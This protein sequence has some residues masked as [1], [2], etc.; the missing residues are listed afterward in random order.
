MGP[1]LV[2]ALFPTG[3]EWGAPFRSLATAIAGDDLE[4]EKLR[5]TL[6][7]G[8][9]QPELPTDVDYVRVMS[10][11]KSKGLTADLVVVM[12]C[13]E[14]LLPTLEDDLSQHEEARKL[15]EQRRLFYIAITRTRQ[16]LLL[17]SV[18]QLPRDIA[19]RMGARVKGGNRHRANTIASR[20]LNELGPSRPTAVSG[21]SILTNALP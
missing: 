8:I 5:E 1:V 21:G 12:G 13:V 15:A 18:T 14:G 20:F 6:Q 17:S 19:F 9:T 16:T 11:H 2:D 10:L 4:P 7:I 3:E